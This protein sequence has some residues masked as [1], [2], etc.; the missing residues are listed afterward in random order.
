MWSSGCLGVTVNG[1]G[2]AQPCRLLIPDLHTKVGDVSRQNIN[3]SSVKLLL[4]ISNAESKKGV[5]YAK[6]LVVKTLFR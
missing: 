4:K 5:P 2:L 6:G 1:R 3:N